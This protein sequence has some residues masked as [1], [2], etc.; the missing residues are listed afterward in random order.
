VKPPFDNQVATGLIASTT[1]MAAPAL[2]RCEGACVMERS[3][4]DDDLGRS[5]GR[6]EGHSEA[7]LSAE[8]RLLADQLARFRVL[9]TE[10]LAREAKADLWHEG[11]FEA[12][13]KL[14]AKQGAIVLLPEGFVALPERRSR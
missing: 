1:I 9:T 5:L 13:L 2:S 12:A 4:T 3:R 14:G 10:E 8:V 7:V 11:T 6:H